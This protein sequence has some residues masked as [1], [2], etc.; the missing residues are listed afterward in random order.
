MGASVYKQNYPCSDG[1]ANCPSTPAFGT[2]WK[3][4]FEFD[5]PTIAPNLTYDVH[6]KATDAAGKLL[7]ELTADFCIAQ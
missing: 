2:E 6:V 7:F 1:D 4:L 3:G 5:V